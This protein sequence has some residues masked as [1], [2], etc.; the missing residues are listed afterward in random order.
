MNNQQT[1]ISFIKSISGQKS[2]LTIPRVFIELTNDI[3]AALFLSQCIY[4]S[5]KTTRTDGYFYKTFDE[6]EEETTLTRFK[7]RACLKK[8]AGIIETKKIMANGS[9]TFHYHVSFDKLYNLIETN[10]NKLQL[11]ETSTSRN[12]HLELEETSTS[13]LE[14]T[15]TSITE[16]TKKYSLKSDDKIYY[17]S[18]P[19]EAAG[20]RY[21]QIFET[22][23][24]GVFPGIS[25]WKTVIDCMDFFL[26]K[27]ETANKTVEYLKPFWLRWASSKR[28]NGQPYA[29]TN[30]NWLTDWAMSGEMPV[31]QGQQ[32]Y[33]R[34][35]G[36]NNIKFYNEVGN[37]A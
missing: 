36:L 31:M 4:W 23:T 28:K 11:E 7:V 3:E 13:E 6:W 24:N 20:N 19:L 16:T 25:D 10:L 17:P 12:L 37:E 30:I 26:K 27:Y 21:L 15:S 18:T 35:K 8:C 33:S 29:K 22:V 1:V 2:I 9:M 14:E 32:Q 34:D 5:D